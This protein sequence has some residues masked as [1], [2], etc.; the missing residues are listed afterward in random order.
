MLEEQKNTVVA[1]RQNIDKEKFDKFV[2]YGTGINAESIVN[3]CRDYTIA[4]IM[5]V[6]KT[7]QSFCGLP[8]LSQEEILERQIHKIIVVAR[9]AVHTIIYKRIR[10]WCMEHKIDVY[11][12]YGKRIEEKLQAHEMDS[13]YFSVSYEMLLKEINSHEIIS[14]DIF[15][16]VLMR[17]LYE[18]RDLFLLLDSEI[19]EKTSCCFS[20]M[21]REAELELLEVCE[22]DLYKIYAKIR[23]KYYLSQ[24]LCEDLMN[25]ELK[26]EREVLTV[27]KRMKECIEYCKAQRKRLFFVSDMY[28]PS[29]ILKELLGQFGITGY[30]DVLVSCEY[31][32]S[33][34]NGLFQVLKEKTRG[35]SYL[36][37][38]DNEEAD[39]YGAIKSGIDSFLILPSMRMLELSA[40]KNVL[41]YLTGLES[42]VMLGIFAEQVFNDP[43]ALYHSQGKPFLKQPRDFGFI[44]IGPFIA[45]YLVWMLNS[46]EK[47]GKEL[48]LFSARDGW[49]VREAYHIL[50][51]KWKLMGL[52]ED[53][54]FMI[55]RKAVLDI[56]K[57]PEGEKGI[58]YGKYLTSLN[59][60][61]YS[62][63][64][65][66][67]FMSRG[68]CQTKLEKFIGTR[69]KGLY[70]Q[71]SIS[72]DMDKDAI[73][74][75]AYFKEALAY[76]S[77]LRIFAMCDFLECIL[78]SYEPSFL[79]IEEDGTFVFDMEKRP[80]EQIE[81][82]REIHKGILDYCDIF[83]T[84]LEGPP[85]QMPPVEFCDEILKYTDGDFSHI[86]I[87]ALKNFMLDDWLGGDKNT[88]MDVLA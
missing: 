84:I 8:I 52:P 59:L 19:T 51:S 49:I 66:F 63:I 17:R 16:T 14:F 9:P 83:S 85:K 33:K 35:S 5:D 42:R 37:I 50:K 86:D 79:G 43:F 48:L 69:M 23:E 78:T 7:G 60:D 54:Y 29:E 65:F 72:G 13:P 58:A 80:A 22:P 88:G 15:D 4:G 32:V 20:E 40:Y 68:T 76:G 38:G 26:K 3:N 57:E 77:N 55:S 36:H 41:A 61:K 71:K 70:F 24:E 74:V 11:D 6:A 12:I 46:F 47:K 10:T 25:R 62:Q 67:D 53:L 31:N 1:F 56:E 44:F 34:V 27:R 82:L 87:P 39:Y 81:C 21:R 73:D 64:Y 28:L 45:S 30:E 2:I 75:K 18:P